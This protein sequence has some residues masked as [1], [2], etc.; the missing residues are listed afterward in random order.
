LVKPLAILDPQWRRLDELFAA[1]DLQALGQLC[2]LVWARDG[3]MPETLLSETIGRATFYLAANPLMGVEQIAT[4]HKLR[5]IIE[6]YGAFPDT[7]DYAACFA[8]GIE[9]LSTGPGMR[10][11][12]AEMALAMA[13]S[14]A[15]GLV[16]EHENFRAGKE[17]WFSDN[18]ETDFSLYG[19][20]V[21]FVGFGQIA[22]EC[23]RLLKPFGPKI[24]AYDPW[25]SPE[26]ANEYGVRL[27]SLDEVARFSRCLF[28]TAA[29]TKSNK[30]LVDAAT[31]EQLP[32]KALVVV[33]SRA[34]VVDFGALTAA[35]RRGAIRAAIDVHPVEPPPMDDPI[36]SLSEVILSPH[37]AAAV[38]NGRQLMGH[39][40][41][42]DIRR[43]IDGSPPANLAR[44]TP[45]HIDELAGI[46]HSKKLEDMCEER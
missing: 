44:A 21:G 14:G 27:I 24:V 5:A 4:A 15:R 36:R 28:V 26:L 16:Q 31:I 45:G 22:R 17:H 43:M 38:R 2:E 39:L 34:H 7:V 41:V 13:L 40:I 37:R 18:E 20:N 33:V 19:A 30:G 35:V 9:V 6:L 46:Q 32:R 1:D 23:C 3:H 10:N 29:P 8:R 12:V 25:V 11:S 42:E